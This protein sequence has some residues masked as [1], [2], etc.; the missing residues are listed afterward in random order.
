[1]CG[2]LIFTFFS[3]LLAWI[4]DWSPRLAARD[5]VTARNAA[6]E[7]VDEF[8]RYR[9]VEKPPRIEQKSALDTRLDTLNSR[10]R[11]TNKAAQ[12][13]SENERR[14]GKASEKGKI[15]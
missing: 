4:N 10:L 11:S 15:N 9:G 13:V 5:D 1:M 3:D 6:V 7:R 2:L 8:R 12:F 14:G